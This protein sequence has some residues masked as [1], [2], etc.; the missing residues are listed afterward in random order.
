MLYSIQYVE[1]VL[2]P[3]LVQ[4]ITLCTFSSWA[5]VP[6]RQSNHPPY[7][8]DVYTF[9]S[10]SLSFLYVSI[11]DLPLSSQGVEGVMQFPTTALLII[12]PWV[13]SI[14]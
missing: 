13:T 5:Q 7:S 8:Y 9:L 1:N 6:I 3:V 2:L 4:Q 14:G 12:M 10:L 11:S